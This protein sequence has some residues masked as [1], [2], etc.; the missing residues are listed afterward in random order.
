MEHDEVHGKFILTVYVFDAVQF[1][2]FAKK[3]PIAKNRHCFPF[4]SRYDYE[5]YNEVVLIF[6]KAEN[7][8][9]SKLFHK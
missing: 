1:C 2:I 5:Y 6:A 4:Y 7:R 3:L 8:Q 9:K